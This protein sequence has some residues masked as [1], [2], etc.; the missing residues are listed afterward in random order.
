M[1]HKEHKHA[2]GQAVIEGV[3]MMHNN[4]VNTSVRVG[5]KIISKTKRLKKKNKIKKMFFIRGI[6][7]LYEMMKIGIESLIWSADQQTEHHENEKISKTEIAFSLLMAFLFTILIFIVA[8]F[9]LTKLI[10]KTHGIIFNI[11]D[12]IIRVIIFLIYLYTI[13]LMKD[14]KMVFQYHGAEHK[15][16]NCY[17]A[18]KE[19]T[20][21]NVKKFSTLHPRCGTS[22][23]IIVLVISIIIFSFITTP[24]AYYKLLLRVLFLPVIA[25]ISYEILKLSDR[26]KQNKFFSMI[27][28]PGLLIQKITTKEPTKKQIEVAIHSLKKVI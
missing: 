5:N 21:T 8:P 18:D 12:G 10:Y 4:K 23:I 15:T 25:G 11:I 16:V 22:F 20:V 2:G 26:F 7:N 24:K 9:Y 13:S 28:K 6:I 14:I 1:K 19:L 17:E 27:S 3:M